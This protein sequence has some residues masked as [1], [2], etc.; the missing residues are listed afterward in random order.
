MR[1]SMDCKRYICISLIFIL[2]LSG[3]CQNYAQAHSLFS[4][5]N[6][7]SENIQDTSV[8][9][10]STCTLNGHD[11]CTGEVMGIRSD[12]RVTQNRSRSEKKESRLHTMVVSV[13]A[14][15]LEISQ[16]FLKSYDGYN[17]IL[18][19]SLSVIICYIHNQGSSK[20]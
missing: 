2:M 19:Q 1:F 20:G 15:P 16:L 13:L 12:N 6:F 18:S 7:S 8:Y 4:Y 9:T 17:Q 10:T 3:M 11:L 5:E 14:V